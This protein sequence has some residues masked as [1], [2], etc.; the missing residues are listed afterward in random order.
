M[1]SRSRNVP[2]N[3]PDLFFGGGGTGWVAGGVGGWTAGVS[4][5][6]VYHT[7]TQRPAVFLTRCQKAFWRQ[8]RATSSLFFSSNLML[9]SSQ[10]LPCEPLKRMRDRLGIVDS[11]WFS[12]IID[13]NHVTSLTF[14][15]T[16]GKINRL[17]SGPTR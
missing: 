5:D 15:S 13:G 12:S 17:V 7:S 9:S 3:M 14:F 4:I 2:I 8:R 11:A 6:L 10:R 1:P 16:M